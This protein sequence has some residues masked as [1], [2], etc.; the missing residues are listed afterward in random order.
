VGPQAE[1]WAK[2]F[3]V[4]LAFMGTKGFLASKGAFES[5]MPTFR[6]KQIIAQQCARLTLLVDHSKFGQ[7]ALSK[8]LD[9]SRIHTV[10][11]DEKAPKKELGVLRS[12][13]KT[14]CIAPL[15]K[16]GV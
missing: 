10:V 4:D 2:T 1:E 14:V 6:I 16:Q 9:I 13:R 5:F 7:R 11:T 12:L 8:A 3:F 15:N